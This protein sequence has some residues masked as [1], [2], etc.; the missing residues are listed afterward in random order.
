MRHLIGEAYEDTFA[1]LV[2]PNASMPLFGARN[3]WIDHSLEGRSIGTG[4][5]WIDDADGLRCEDIV[6]DSNGETQ[7]DRERAALIDH[8]HSIAPSLV[9]RMTRV[10]NHL[11]PRRWLVSQGRMLDLLITAPQAGFAEPWWRTMHADDICD[12][13][14]YGLEREELLLGNWSSMD[15]ILRAA[16][17]RV[18][19]IRRKKR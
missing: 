10:S 14:R 13:V 3:A 8:L 18:K 4:S 5:W 17:G 7:L 16:Q 19:P 15:Q 9:E 2:F 6:S 1:E 12:V 11:N